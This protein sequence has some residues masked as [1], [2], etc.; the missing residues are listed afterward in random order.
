[1]AK[2]P[3]KQSGEGSDNYGNAAK[4]MA[5]AAKNAGKTAKAATDA[6][7][8]TANAAASTVKG[9]AKVGKA[10]ASIAKGTAAGGVWGAIIAAAWLLRH[11]LFKI[12]VCVCMF[13]LILIIVIVSLPIIVFENLVGYN[14]DG[15]GEGM[16]ALYAS[17]DDLSLSIADTINGAYQSTFGNV[18]N[19]ITLGGYDR[20]MSLLNLVDKAVGNVQYDTCYILASYSVSMLQQGTSKEN[21]LGK[22]E[23]VSDKMFPISYEECSVTRTVLQDG[24]ELLECISYLACTILPFD[25][26]VLLDAFSLDLDAKYEDLNMTNGEYVEYLSNSLKKTLGNRVN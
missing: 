5:K 16:S 17:Y 26:S 21:L 7:R 22:I 8:A 10:A 25:S 19:M 4:N 9:G 6:T 3:T 23:S 18:M 1:M 11:T 13:V 14:K 15:Y 20:A 2:E 12:L 24:V